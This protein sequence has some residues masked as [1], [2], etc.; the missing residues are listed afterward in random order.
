MACMMPICHARRRTTGPPFGEIPFGVA[1]I[2]FKEISIREAGQLSGSHQNCLGLKS[3]NLQ[4]HMLV[5]WFAGTDESSDV[6]SIIFSY[7]FLKA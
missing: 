1:P 5:R 2:S 6:P 7:N 4:Y 3:V